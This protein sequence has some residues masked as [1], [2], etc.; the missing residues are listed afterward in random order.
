MKKEYSWVKWLILAM[1]IMEAFFAIPV[2]GGAFIMM[3]FWTP[4]II[5]LA[6]HIVAL[7][8]MVKSG[9][10]RAQSI[11]GICASTIGIIPFVGWILHI[12][13]AVFG[14]LTFHKMNK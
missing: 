7:V 9:G 5:A 8:F 1:A 2:M 3:L 6:G 12:L 11:L 4:L 13:A 10:P 14:F